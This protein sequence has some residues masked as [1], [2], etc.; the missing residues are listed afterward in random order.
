MDAKIKASFINSMTNDSMISCSKCGTKNNSDSKFCLSCGAELDVPQ[1]ES[2]SAPAFPQH[3]EEPATA[4][5]ASAPYIEP[6]SVFAE[7]LP[8]WNVEPPQLIVKRH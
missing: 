3:A 5:P 8:S 4:I 2:A 6:E 1:N 7:G